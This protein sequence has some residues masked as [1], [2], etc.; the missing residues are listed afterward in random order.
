MF[1]EQE[2]I[3][4]IWTYLKMEYINVELMEKHF[5]LLFI[6]CWY[7]NLILY[8]IYNFFILILCFLLIYIYIV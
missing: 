5:F 8:Y 4:S 7:Y 2:I 6:L 1:E 3:V